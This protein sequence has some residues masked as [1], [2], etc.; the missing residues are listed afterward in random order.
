MAPWCRTRLTKSCSRHRPYPGL[1][2]AGAR[3][4]LVVG[5]TYGYDGSLHEL[6]SLATPPDRGDAVCGGRI[7][8]SRAAHSCARGATRDSVATAPQ[9]ACGEP[10]A[11]LVLS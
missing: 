5:P 8:D 7:P 6:G 9:I 3:C 1:V 11:P 4:S 10:P 2:T